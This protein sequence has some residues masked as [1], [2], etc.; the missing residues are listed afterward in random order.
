MFSPARAFIDRLVGHTCPQAATNCVTP[1][2]IRVFADGVNVLVNGD[3]FVAHSCGA[4]DSHTPFVRLSTTSPRVL[5]GGRTIA[6]KGSL[7]TTDCLDSID[8]VKAPPSRVL[9]GV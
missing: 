4:L 5:V 2:N 9:I 1:Q 3:F 6:L 8:A 7:F